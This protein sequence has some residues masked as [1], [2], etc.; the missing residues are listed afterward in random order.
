MQLPHSLPWASGLICEIS[1][2]EMLRVTVAL[3]PG[4]TAWTGSHLY[5][6][7]QEQRP[8]LFLCSKSFVF[9]CH[10]DEAVTGDD[11]SS[12][13]IFFPLFFMSAT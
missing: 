6:Q 13:L 10:C 12:N 1:G 2:F 9:L 4:R 7:F 8:Y 11:F 5:V 3:T